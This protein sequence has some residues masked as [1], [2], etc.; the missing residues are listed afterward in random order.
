VAYYHSFGIFGSWGIS[1]LIALLAGFL[2]F[3]FKVRSGYRPF[4]TI[5]KKV[6]KEIMGFSFA[7]YGADFFWSASSLVLPIMVLN[8]LGAEPNAYFYIAWSV[9]TVCIL[10]SG[11]V[12]M[13]LFA[14][15]SYDE[16]RLG[17]NIWRS[18]RLIFL[19]LI[20]LVILIL[21]IAPQLLLL[22]GGSYAGS[23]AGLLR[24][25]AISSLPWSINLVYL[26][27]LRVEKK[28]KA[29]IIFT[30]F[31]A[32]LALGSSY[33]LLPRM[34][35]N[36]V[37][38]AWLATHGVIALAVTTTSLKGRQLINSIRTFVFRNKGG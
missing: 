31:T 29:L 32:V 2:F 18:L 21:I 30:A 3:F 36:G 8:L 28:L 10:V 16:E 37:G 6:M 19:T 9:G 14:E 13:S 12:S 25:M 24:L 4:I 22:F 34:G 11:A 38:I 20:P 15:G 5:R 26:S 17:L 7:N 35:I 1:L 27:K 23:G 33:F